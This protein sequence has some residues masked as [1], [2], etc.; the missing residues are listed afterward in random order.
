VLSYDRYIATPLMSKPV[1]E[2]LTA[3]LKAQGSGFALVEDSVKAVM[4]ISTNRSIN[5]IF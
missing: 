4:W 5:G 1:I 2:R 3:Q